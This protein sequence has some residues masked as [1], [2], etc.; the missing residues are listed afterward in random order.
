[1]SIPSR[2]C[3]RKPLIRFWRASLDFVIGLQTQDTSAPWEKPA[4]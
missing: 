2:S 1:M 3:G 4:F